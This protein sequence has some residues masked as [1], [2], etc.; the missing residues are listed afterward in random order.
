MPVVTVT[1][2]AIKELN[3]IIENQKLDKEKVCLRIRICGGGCSGF[4]TK[5]DLDETYDEKTDELD[6]VE[7]I[8]VAVDKRSALY[9][10]GASVDFHDSLDKRGFV[11][12]NPNAVSKCGCG[13]SFSM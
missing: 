2:N 13:S 11:V 4:S 5:L 12:D 3:H 9:L 10:Q 1:E 6:V 7:G 8:R